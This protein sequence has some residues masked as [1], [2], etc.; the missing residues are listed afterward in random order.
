MTQTNNTK[1]DTIDEVRPMGVLS[2]LGNQALSKI[3]PNTSWG[4]TATGKLD[5]GQIANQAWVSFKSYLGQIGETPTKEN[6]ITWLNYSKYP[7]AAATAAE[8]VLDKAQADAEAKAA[9][10][11]PQAQA[12][13]DHFIGNN[14]TAAIPPSAMPRPMAAESKILYLHGNDLMR[15]YLDIMCEEA[16]V[17]VSDKTAAA[18]IKAAVQ[19]SAKTQYQTPTAV[20]PTAPPATAPSTSTAPTAPPATA[21]GT[22]TAPTQKKAPPLQ[23][24]QQLAQDFHEALLATNDPKAR[25]LLTALETYM[26]LAENLT[27]SS[28]FNPGKMLREKFSKTKRSK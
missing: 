27:F 1:K 7:A 22:S 4:A 15:S 28:S 13:P 6:I 24:V 21:P 8:A 11:Q 17:A 2:K 5:T 18:A 9:P 19:A 12:Q 26:Q 23:D 16:P 10:A 20:A 25:T 3:A 14:P